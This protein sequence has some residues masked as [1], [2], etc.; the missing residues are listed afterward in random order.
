MKSSAKR[1]PVSGAGSRWRQAGNAASKRIIGDGAQEIRSKA[2]EPEY[3]DPFCCMQG[4]QA[5]EFVRKYFA[6][7]SLPLIIKLD[8]LK[9]FR[10]VYEI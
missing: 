3:S 5:H 2:E 10:L 8:I 6:N 4:R 1:S 7:V 9:S